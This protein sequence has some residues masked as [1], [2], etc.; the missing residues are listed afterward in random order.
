MACSPVKV[1]VSTSKWGKIPVLLLYNGVFCG[2]RDVKSH[3][4]YPSPQVTSILRTKTEYKE[5]ESL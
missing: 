5:K 4:M 1:L 2:E 3:V